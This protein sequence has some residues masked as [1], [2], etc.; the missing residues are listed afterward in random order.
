MTIT[1]PVQNPTAVQLLEGTLHYIRSYGWKQGGFGYKNPGDTCPA[2]IRGALRAAVG[3]YPG[4]PDEDLP[5]AFW[6]ARE[7]LDNAIP[8]IY[9]GDGF[10]VTDVAEYNDNFAGSQEDIEALILRA[11]DYAHTEFTDQA[12]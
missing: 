8:E 3:Y 4:M 12:A 1:L 10:H 2:C 6:Q 7:A 9:D 5:Q 11:I